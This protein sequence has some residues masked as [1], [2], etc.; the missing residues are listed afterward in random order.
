MDILFLLIPVSVVLVLFILASLWWAVE[1]G[2]FDDVDREGERILH[3][4]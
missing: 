3:N 4:D 2:Q 1:R